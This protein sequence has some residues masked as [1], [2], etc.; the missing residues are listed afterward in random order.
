MMPAPVGTVQGTAETATVLEQAKEEAGKIIAE[1]QAAIQSQKMAALTE[2]KNQVG[3]LVI[4][5]SEK[6][7]R[8]QLDNATAQESHIQGLVNDVK[9]N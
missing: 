1:A 9:L 6:V 8:K 2:V 7:L 3:K 5:V 4:E